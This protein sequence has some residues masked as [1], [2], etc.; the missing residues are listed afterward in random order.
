MAE[1]QTFRM[2]KKLAATPVVGKRLFSLTAALT[3]PY[4]RTICPKL[5]TMQPG[6]AVAR[7]PAWWGVR[8]H[9]KSVHAIAACNLAEFAMGML[10]EASVP[11][12]HRWVPK[13]MTTNY[14][15]ISVGGLTAV[16]KAEL[17]DFSTIAPET[18]GV[19]F[20]VHIVLTDAN[21]TEVQDATINCWVTAK[22]P[23]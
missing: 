3:A 13:G 1:T 6:L 12:T 22:K 8:N 16:A 19:D 7:M 14:K 10:C 21:G 11:T 17:P 5:E 9:I 20:P 23:K 15:R 18:G 4:F 2:W